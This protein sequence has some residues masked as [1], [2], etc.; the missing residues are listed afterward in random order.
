MNDIGMMREYFGCECGSLPH[1][2]ELTYFKPRPNDSNEDSDIIYLHLFVEQWR[3]GIFP[4][5]GWEDI[6]NF[7]SCYCPFNSHLYKDFYCG[8]IYKRWVI[9]IQHFFGKNTFDDTIL[10]GTG[11]MDIDELKRLYHFLEYLDPYA[12]KEVEEAKEIMLESDTYHL[13]ILI[14]DLGD[15]KFEDEITTRFQFKP[16][17]GLK[18]WWRAIKYGF[19]CCQT[20]YGIEDEFVI[21]PK[22]ATLLKKM[23]QKVIKKNEEV[24]SKNKSM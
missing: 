15:P 20:N 14:D 23:V 22:D 12:P 21:T 17:K 16:Q 13:Q 7:N 6:F 19:G 4:W 24:E 18:R 8:S 9:A 3:R 11:I 1:V 5:F 10:D 2:F